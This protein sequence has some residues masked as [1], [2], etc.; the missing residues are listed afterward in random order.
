MANIYQLSQELL[1]IFDI[2]EENEG[3]ITPEL[4]AA[5]KI[6]QQSFSD[7][8]KDYTNVVK[9][10]QNDIIDI[11]AEKA[12][13]NDLQKSKEKIIEK[14]KTIII[15][16]IET[17]GNVNKSGT[18]FIDYGTGKVSIRNSQAVEVEEDD[19][20]RF[21]NR[22]ISALE[23]YNMNGQ[24]NK[25]IVD[26]YNILTYANQNPDEDDLI[27]LNYTLKDI[28][29]LN[30][31][32]KLKVSLKDIISSEKGFAVI[33]SLIDYGAFNIDGSVDKTQIKREAKDNNFVPSFARIVNNKNLTIK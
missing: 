33:K 27:D 12:R 31:D 8:I 23:W 19:V 10:L 5:L 16:A 14:L 29:T 9:M 20:N 2:I 3:E 15:E 25:D 28:E 30:A 17:F 32:V 7:K 18:K 21:V 4:D 26:P 6:T 22:F 11:K 13:L 24:L 1:S